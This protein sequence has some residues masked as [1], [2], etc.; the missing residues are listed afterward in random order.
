VLAPLV[1]LQ[2]RAEEGRTIDRPFGTRLQLPHFDR[3]RFDFAQL[4]TFPT[5][6]EREVDLK[7][8]IGPRTARPLTL[9]FP[10]M[11][12]PMAYGLALSGPVKVALAKGA[13]LAGTASSTGDGP[14]FPAERAAARY[15][16]VQYGR[17]G[18]T[19]VPAALKQADAI[20]L[21]VGSGARG[22]LGAV[23]APTALDENLR[24]MMG[25]PPG[26]AAVAP[27]RFPGVESVADLRQL[28]DDLRRL[29]GG[30]PVGV[31]LS[32]GMRLED[33]L[34]LVA[35]AGA[36][37]VSLGG[38]QAGTWKSPVSVQDDF[39]VPTLYGLARAARFL[40]RE[41][42]R[43]RLSLI[44]GGNLR[45]PGEFLKAVALGADAVY[46]GTVALLALVH[47]QILKTLPGLPPTEL[48]GYTSKLGKRFDQQ[49]AVRS[50]SNFLISCQEEMGEGLRAL[51]KT[52]LS[53]L[54]RDDLMALDPVTARACGVQLA[55][56]PIRPRPT[57]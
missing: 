43:G 49:E 47:T 6:V 42:L 26:Q 51:G 7:T 46:I 40:E 38:A 50:L 32:A 18:W 10:V 56:Q 30:V 14:F 41:G 45:T 1:W 44:V 19:Q 8:V 12:A 23:E 3:L 36:D 15:L 13:G 37:F 34:A 27:A 11:I 29:S 57:R 17:A 35:A 2:A 25:V 53:Q 52:S 21:E 28:I 16:I 9:A 4:S 54:S 33:D 5:P 39:G 22:G 31:K 24:T 48:I 20:E 55:Y